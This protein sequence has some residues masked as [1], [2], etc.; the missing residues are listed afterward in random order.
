MQGLLLNIR[1]NIQSLGSKNIIKQLTATLPIDI[2]QLSSDNP[3]D[4]TINKLIRYINC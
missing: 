1:L 4:N 2:D 3:E